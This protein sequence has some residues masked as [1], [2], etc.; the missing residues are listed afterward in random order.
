MSAPLRWP[1]TLAFAHQLT[2]AIGGNLSL[3]N[4]DG[5]GLCAQIEL[6]AR[7]V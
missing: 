5:G 6:P 1:R 3:S 4:R 2:L 7:G